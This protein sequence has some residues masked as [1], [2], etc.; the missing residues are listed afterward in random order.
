[1]GGELICGVDEAGRGPLAGPVTAAAVI[2]PDEFPF[3]LLADSKSLSPSKRELAAGIIR[4][5]S[6]AWA[7]GWTWP[8]EIDRINIHYATLL[9]MERAVRGLAVQPSLV[10]V[11]GL[12]TPNVGIRSAAIVKGDSTVHQI[13]AA[14][15]IAK[16]LRDAWMVRYARV[17]PGYGFERHKGYPTKEHRKKI[18]ELGISAI[19]RRSFRLTSS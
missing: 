19:H 10:L 5:R 14:S 6:V 16:T 11:D 7:A 12:F 18:E 2:L 8:G 9:A 3:E 13:M 1:M 4:S 17:A 15:I